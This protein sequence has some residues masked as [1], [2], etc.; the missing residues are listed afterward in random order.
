MLKRMI[1]LLSVLAM[2]GCGGVDPDSPL[3]KRKVI[4]KEMLNLSEDLGGML[5]GR[6][7]FDEQTFAEKA[8]RL[9]EISR[10]PWQ[11]FDAEAKESKSSARDDVWE[12]RERFMQLAREL[13]GTTALLLQSAQQQPLNPDALGVRIDVVEKACEGCH[14]EFRIY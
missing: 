11:H 6:I 8:R 7:A 10:Q 3:G 9:D 2:S 14:Q 12:Q 4:F 13:E 1:V 5:R